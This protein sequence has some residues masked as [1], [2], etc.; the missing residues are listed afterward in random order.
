MILQRNSG[1]ASA[2]MPGQLVFVSEH[3]VSRM[4]KKAPGRLYES[5]GNCPE[6]RN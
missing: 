2:E 6:I 1:I 3:L 5:I 4:D